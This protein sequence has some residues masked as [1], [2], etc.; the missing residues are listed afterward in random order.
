LIVSK[1][2]SEKQQQFAAEYLRD[3]SATRAYLRAGY[4]VSEKVAGVNA[5]KL[6]GNARVQEL[7]HKSM[8]KRAER[9]QVS[10][11][12]VV[13]QLKGIAFCVEERTQDQLRALELLGRHLGMFKDRLDATT[14]TKITVRVLDGPG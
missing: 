2:L 11:D 8:A 9:C 4:K 13:L 14:D 5:C 6:L 1:P 12:E 7:I 10:Q 3:L